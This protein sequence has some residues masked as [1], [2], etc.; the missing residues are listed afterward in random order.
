MCVRKDNALLVSSDSQ[1][2]C[3]SCQLVALVLIVQHLYRY[4]HAR[5]GAPAKI[6]FAQLG[7]M[8]ARDSSTW[9]VATL[10]S[11]LYRGV[12]LQHLRPYQKT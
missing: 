3:R 11:T 6:R 1:I 8:V 2:V 7:L 12:D 10:A 5:G 4:P 9:I